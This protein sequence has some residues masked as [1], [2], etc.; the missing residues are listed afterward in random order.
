MILNFATTVLKLWSGTRKRVGG[1][2]ITP[3]G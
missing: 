1:Y 3:F 2:A